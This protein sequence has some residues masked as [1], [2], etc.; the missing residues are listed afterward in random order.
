MSSLLHKLERAVDKLL[1]MKESTE[2]P[3]SV[4]LAL[5]ELTSMTL[6]AIL[7]KIE[8]LK[9]SDDSPDYQKGLAAVE[10]ILHEMLDNCV[11][12]DTLPREDMIKTFQHIM[13][14]SNLSPATN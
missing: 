6:C 5:S 4:E 7:A 1:R 8:F 13:K 2:L 9:L 11:T 14:E 3:P 12:A 10:T